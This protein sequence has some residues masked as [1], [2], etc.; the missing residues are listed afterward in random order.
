MRENHGG[1]YLSLCLP[2]MCVQA[3]WIVL[4]WPQGRQDKL[5]HRV[6]TEA[7]HVGEKPFNQQ[8]SHVYLN[9]THF[10]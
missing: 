10:S 7:I 8:Q 6:K 1:A 3:C 4:G 2:T 5:L 9:F